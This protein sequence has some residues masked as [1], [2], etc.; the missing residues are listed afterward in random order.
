MAPPV[1]PAPAR[2]AK[3]LLPAS[4]GAGG[5]GYHRLA[6]G[7]GLGAALSAAEGIS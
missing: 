7:A 5:R 1:S 2:C 3:G 4:G 6:A